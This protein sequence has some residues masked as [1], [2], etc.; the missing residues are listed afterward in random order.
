MKVRHPPTVAFVEVLE[1]APWKR[2]AIAAIFVVLYA[3]TIQLWVKT[4]G[5][6]YE[7][8]MNEQKRIVKD[9]AAE[10]RSGNKTV[11]F[12][13]RNKSKDNELEIDYES[14]PSKILPSAWACGLIFFTTHV[15]FH[16]C[17]AWMVSFK[18]AMFFQSARHVSHGCF[19]RVTPLANK[20]NADI[21]RVEESDISLKCTFNFQYQL[22]ECIEPGKAGLDL[23]LN[24]DVDDW[25]VR[26]VRSPVDLRW[27]DYQSAKGLKTESEVELAQDTFGANVFELPRPTFLQLY[28]KQLLGPL[29]I[30]QLFCTALWMLDTYWKYTCFTLVSVLGFEASTAFQRLKS[31]ATLRGMSMKSYNVYVYRQGSW[32]ER[33]IEELL[34]G[35]IFSLTGKKTR[36]TEKRVTRTRIL[37]CLAIASCSGALQSSMRRRLLVSPCRR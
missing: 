27:K 11:T 22:Y 18:A 16:L 10:L 32:A 28:K 21:C 7:W 25:G 15:F 20:G 8:G 17:I 30:F 33:L 5:E 3:I 26:L 13:S 29:C 19:M 35:D 6:P 9:K 23:D 1:R 24:G 2:H 14:L 34:P 37:W 31:M 4:A 12:A 36:R